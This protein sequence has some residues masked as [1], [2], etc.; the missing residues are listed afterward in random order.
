[1]MVPARMVRDRVFG[2]A[3]EKAILIALAEHAGDDGTSIYP[4]VSTIADD[5]DVCVRTV[6]RT[7]TK[8]TEVG[9]LVMTEEARQ[10][11]PRTYRINL[12]VLADY[13]L[14][15]TGRRRLERQQQQ[16]TTSPSPGVTPMSSLTP[17]GEPPRGD[18][19][20]PRGDT[21]DARGDIACHP[22]SRVK[23]TDSDQTRA[24]EGT[25][26]VGPPSTRDAENPKSET[27]SA[28]KQDGAADSSA[29][30]CAAWRAAVPA[31]IEA[32]GGVAEYKAWVMHLTPLSDDGRK[33]VVGAPSSPFWIDY[34][35]Q[36]H[37]AGIE[38]AVGRRVELRPWPSSDVAAAER[39]KTGGWC[40]EL[41][42][43]WSPP[44]GPS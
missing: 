20:A 39:I 1:M 11:K 4:A 2:S 26:S 18:I 5:A 16:R 40:G 13:P 44:A 38:A 14:S 7:I 9:L 22:T 41:K 33:M 28:G 19:D 8:Y 10:H 21:Q 27:N 25:G 30:A 34:L 43:T 35:R 17:K 32:V 24:R 6:Q 42:P 23:P 31:I 36:N 3:T 37:L 12:D 15:E 29:P